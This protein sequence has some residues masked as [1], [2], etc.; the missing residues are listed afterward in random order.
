MLVAVLAAFTPP[1][2][3]LFSERAG[4]CGAGWAPFFR[5]GLSAEGAAVSKIDGASH[6]AERTVGGRDRNAEGSPCDRQ[7]EEHSRRRE[8]QGLNAECGREASVAAKRGWGGAGWRRGLRVG[9][10]GEG[11]GSRAKGFISRPQL[12]W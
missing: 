3:H 11:A 1:S 10:G 9:E 5:M 2:V 7:K 12:S 6:G 8:R 4:A